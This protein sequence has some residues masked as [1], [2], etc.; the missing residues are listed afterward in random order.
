MK[1]ILSDYFISW[2][3][4]P[5]RTSFI[6]AYINCGATGHLYRSDRRPILKVLCVCMFLPIKEGATNVTPLYKTPASLCLTGLIMLSM[7]VAEVHMF[8]S[9]CRQLEFYDVI[10]VVHHLRMTIA[11]VVLVEEMSIPISTA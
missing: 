4:T 1:N 6:V 8:S 11:V 2:I 5:P 9:W 7:S 3:R 10:L